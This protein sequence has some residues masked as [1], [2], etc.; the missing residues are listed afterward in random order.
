MCFDQSWNDMVWRQ[1]NPV[2]NY[3]FELTILDSEKVEV[4]WLHSRAKCSDLSKLNDEAPKVW[5]DYT[6]GNTRKLDIW[7]KSILSKEEQLPGEKSK[8]SEIL[9]QLNQ[10]GAIQFESVVVELFRNLPH[11]NHKKD[12]LGNIMLSRSLST[13]RS[14]GLTEWRAMRWAVGGSFILARFFVYFFI[15]WKK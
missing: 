6:N 7:S 1:G 9:R 10:L 14:G 3:R 12:W 15:Q 5:K 4:S 13:S 8:E 2:K 11:V